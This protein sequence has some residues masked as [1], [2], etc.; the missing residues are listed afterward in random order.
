MKLDN[1]VAGAFDIAGLDKLRA[2]AQKDEQG[3]LQQVAEQFEGIFTSMLLKSMRQAN[4]AFKSEDSPLSSRTTEFYEQMHDSQLSLELSAQGA[5]GLADLIVQQLSPEKHNL[6]PATALRGPIKST[7]VSKTALNVEQTELANPQQFVNKLKPLAQK[8]SKA[9]GVEAEVL[10][11]Q[12]A[13]ETGWGQKVIQTS[14]GSSFNLFNIKAD[15][16][17]AGRRQ[18]VNTLEFEQGVAKQTQA[19]FRTY[20][21]FEQSFNDY[22]AFIKDSPRYADALKQG[23]NSE[24]YLRQLHTAGYATDP[25]Y[26]DKA[27][28]IL[29]RIKSGK[30]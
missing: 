11:A 17:W 4:S 2:S 10:L 20:Q 12:A 14:Q 27:I 18:Q 21:N 1:Q 8:A 15:Q 24:Q 6:M 29:Q 9:L 22:V 30:F 5:L 16:R 23:Q 13:L 25:N 26:S 3:S 19:H 28:G 7:N